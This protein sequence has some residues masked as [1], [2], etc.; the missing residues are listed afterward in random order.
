VQPSVRA[1]RFHAREKFEPV[2]DAG[3][4]RPY[5]GAMTMNNIWMFIKAFGFAL[6]FVFV[7][8]DDPDA[9]VRIGLIDENRSN[10]DQHR[11]LLQH[12]SH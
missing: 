3:Y 8:R 2:A 9:G 5:F 10:S 12:Q 6:S 1:I 4:H 7:L 11:C